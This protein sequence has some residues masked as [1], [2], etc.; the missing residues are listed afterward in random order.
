MTIF[1]DPGWSTLVEEAMSYSAIP[2]S[3]LLENES[4]IPKSKYRPGYR[5][6]IHKNTA[7]AKLKWAR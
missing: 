5:K 4:K 3:L 7:F 2:I 6:Q 1:W